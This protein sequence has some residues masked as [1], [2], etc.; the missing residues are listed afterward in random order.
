MWREPRNEP[1]IE[2]V[3]GVFVSLHHQPT[4]RAS[5]RALPQR[6]RLQ[7]LAAVAYLA[8]IALVNNVHVFPE[9]LTF[10]CQH[11]HK[12]VDPPIIVDQAIPELPLALLF[13]SLLL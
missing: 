13:V 11:L 1:F 7:A 5:I 2:V 8:R 6:H 10:V 12:T 3:G 9:A 4:V